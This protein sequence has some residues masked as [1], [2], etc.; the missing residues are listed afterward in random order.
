M[1]TTEAPNTPQEQDIID[2]HKSSQRKT[3]MSIAIGIFF[4]DWL[5][6]GVVLVFHCAL[7]R[8]N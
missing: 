8:R 3:R 6:V 7:S 5:A 4:T 2:A 1:S